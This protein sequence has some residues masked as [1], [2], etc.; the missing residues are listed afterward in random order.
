[1]DRLNGEDIAL[2]KLG[3]IEAGPAPQGKVGRP[4]NMNHYAT[5]KSAAQSMLD[6]AL[7]MANS[8]QLKSVIYVGPNYRFYLPLLVL[9]SLSIT[10]Q[11]MVG[12]LLVFIVKYD[13]ND[14]RKHAKLNR[15]N[16]A[17]TLFVF[18]TVLINIFITALGFEGYSVRSPMSPVMLPEHHHSLLPDD[19]NTT[20]GF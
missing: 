5:K 15:M 14:V 3:D 1:M 11:V 19:L 18:F 12:L 16:N 7:L 2:N 17:A 4:I 8:S 13:L 10:L 20:S 9:L 6:V